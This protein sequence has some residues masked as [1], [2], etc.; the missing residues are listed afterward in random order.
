MTLGA[1]SLV[2]HREPLTGEAI[3]RVREGSLPTVVLLGLAGIGKTTLLCEVARR[4][5]EDLP[6]ALALVFDGPAGR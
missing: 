6:H 4:L 1:R 3:R 2:F 5:R